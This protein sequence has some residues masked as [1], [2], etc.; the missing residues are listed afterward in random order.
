MICPDRKN[1]EWCFKSLDLSTY[2]LFWCFSFIKSEGIIACSKI[3]IVIV[4]E[5][6]FETNSF[7][8][9]GFLVGNFFLF[10]DAT[11]TRYVSHIEL[12]TR[13]EEQQ[14]VVGDME[15]HIYTTSFHRIVVR[16][17][18]KLIYESRF[19]ST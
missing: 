11:D 10:I 2:F 16:I 15:F 3:H 13:V 9:N 7:I 19:L 17:L 6:G 12:V 8:T 18:Q 5:N 14:I 4:K 1:L